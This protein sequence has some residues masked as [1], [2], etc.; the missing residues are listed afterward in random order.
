MPAVLIKDGKGP[1]KN[2]Y[3]GTVDADALDPALRDGEVLIQGRTHPSFY[4]GLLLGFSVL[5]CAIPPA[6]HR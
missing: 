6:V 4:L 2:R 3:I 5:N 1:I